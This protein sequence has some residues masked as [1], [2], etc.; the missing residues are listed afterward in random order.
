MKFQLFFS[1]SWQNEKLNSFESTEYEQNQKKNVEKTLRE[2]SFERK[3]K[4]IRN[5][6]AAINRFHMDKHEFWLLPP[7]L[8]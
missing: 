7:K 6:C 2:K 4:K 5:H 8:F 1:F 3:C